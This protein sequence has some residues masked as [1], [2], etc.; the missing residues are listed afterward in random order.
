M[1]ANAI[2]KQDACAAASSSSGEVSPFDSCERAAQVTGSSP[3]APL[4]KEWIVP[5]PS[6]RLPFQVADAVRSAAIGRPF[7]EVSS[8]LSVARERRRSSQE[9]Y[10]MTSTRRAPSG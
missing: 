6:V 9:R 1:L 8:G 3:S 2:E 10:A 5:V 4:P 7:I